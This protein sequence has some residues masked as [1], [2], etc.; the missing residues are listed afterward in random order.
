MCIDFVCM[1]NA[2]NDVMCYCGFV[3][4]LVCN[5]ACMCYILY[6]QTALCIRVCSYG[7]K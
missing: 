6:V 1:Y 3:M 7:H 2:V 4:S 5:Y